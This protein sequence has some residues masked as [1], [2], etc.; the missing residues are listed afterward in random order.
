[1][2]VGGGLKNKTGNDSGMF[3]FVFDGWLRWESF[4][5]T[6]KRR[7]CMSPEQLHRDV[8]PRS[9]FFVPRSV[10]EKQLAGEEERTEIGQQT[11][12]DHS[13]VIREHVNILETC[14]WR[15]M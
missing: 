3:S 5:K 11:T 12:T 6:T 7:H 13:T 2:A 4:F 15:I 14:L 8:L 9:V 1:M 10:D